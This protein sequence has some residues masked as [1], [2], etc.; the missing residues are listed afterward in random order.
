MGFSF[1]KINIERLTNKLEK[2]NIKTNIDISE[3]KNIKTDFLKTED[4]LISVDFKYFID[5]QENYAKIEF[6]GNSLFSV[7]KIL[8]EKIIKEW[9][10]KKIPKNFKLTLFNIILRKCNIRALELEDEFSLPLHISM[11]RIQENSEKNKTE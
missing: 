3:I 2:V 11:P 8:G 7:D 6:A 1:N 5:Y 4:T 9:E 10:E